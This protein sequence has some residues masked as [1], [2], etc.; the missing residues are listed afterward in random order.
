MNSSGF[1]Y[2]G[3]ILLGW[4]AILL[5]GCGGDTPTL[6]ASMTP[7]AVASPDQG[8]TATLPALAA[9]VPVQ[10]L[11]VSTSAFTPAPDSAAP[12][13]AAP[14]GRF[15][16][17]EQAEEA[18]VEGPEVCL[19]LNVMLDFPN[20]EYDPATGTLGGY[21]GAAAT[22][23]L[24]PNLP[25]VGFAGYSTTMSGTYSYLAAIQTL[26]FTNDLDLA[27]YRET[28]S[29]Q[30]QLTL[31]RVDAVGTVVVSIAGNRMIL[32]PGDAWVLVEISEPSPGCRIESSTTI[33]NYGLLDQSQL[34]V[35]FA[36]AE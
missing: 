35:Q 28:P 33:R 20:Y 29:E 34:E 6:A 25:L 5:A 1:R 31:I 17:V 26:P 27:L 36:E 22:V 32:A 3:M 2:A 24:D 15:L 21:G 18:R 14:Q 30:R 9:T 23:R 11:E 7:S 12:G 8:A 16:F 13:S 4:A 19:N 10:A